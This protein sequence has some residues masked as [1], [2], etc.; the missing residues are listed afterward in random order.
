MR[1]T[2]L[3]RRGPKIGL[4]KQLK[5]PFA[6]QTK[7]LQNEEQ[8]S[9]HLDAYGLVIEPLLGAPIRL[10]AA[11]FFGFVIYGLP[12]QFQWLHMTINL[13]ISNLLTSV[14]AT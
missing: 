1:M 12:V 6:V 9:V 14:T 11:R 2:L 10:S 13:H 5:V 7:F 4:Q 3:D 8:F